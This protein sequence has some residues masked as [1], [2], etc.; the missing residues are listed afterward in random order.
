MSTDPADEQAP[1]GV[2]SAIQAGGP[3]VQRILLGV[4]LRRLREAA[5]ISRN[6]A[7]DAIRAT[8]SKISRLELGRSSYKQRDVADL[9]TLYGITDERER[10]P[11]LA[12]ARQA[13]SPGWW[14][15]YSDIIPSWLELYVGLE[16]AASIIR[17][18]EVQFV[19]GL[20]Q[21]E[22]YARAVIG[23]RHS[24]SDAADV[25]RRVDLRMRRQRLLTR[26]DAPRLWSV[27]DE[28]ALRRPLGGRQVMRGQLEHLMELSMLPNVTLQIVP[29]RTGGHSAAG[30][31]FTILRFPAPDLPDVIYLEQLTSALYLD[32]RSDVDD[33]TETMNQ[34]CVEA[35]HRDSTHRILSA[36]LA[37]T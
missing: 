20:M 33:Y 35:E 31:P 5:G 37:D 29:F 4:H 10:E 19:H 9:L 12:I 30:G 17:T 22:D 6:D 36:I 1:T 34:L 11:L 18:Y 3:T 23:L 2:V 26:P 28:A 32:K 8:Q 13:S 24:K 25:D 21:T 7:A 27:I 14:H 16:E 15:Q